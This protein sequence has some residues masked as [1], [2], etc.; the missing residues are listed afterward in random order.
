M[1]MRRANKQPPLLPKD[2]RLLMP[3]DNLRQEAS[4]PLL[5]DHIKEFVRNSRS[6]AQPADGTAGGGSG[7]GGGEAQIERLGALGW[8]KVLGQRERGLCM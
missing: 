1:G 5:L 4:G 8:L 3:G 6:Q 7:S 2:P